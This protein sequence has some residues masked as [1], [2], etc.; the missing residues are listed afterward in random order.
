MESAS[1]KRP[2]EQPGILYKFRS[3]VQRDCTCLLVR[4]QL[5]CCTYRELNDPFDCDP[6]IE[7][8]S[9]D[10]RRAFIEYEL[11]RTPAELLEERR[12][13]LELIFLSPEH[14][15]TWFI[16]AT[17]RFAGILSLSATRDNPLLWAHYARNYSGFAVGYRAKD[18][19][20]LKALPARP[21]VYASERPRL[22]LFA[23]E[24]FENR[25]LLFVKAQH[26]SYEQEWRYLRMEYP[27]GAG[28]ITVPES[29]IVEVCLGPRIRSEDRRVV[30]Q[31]AKQLHDRPRIMQAKL[32]TDRFGLIFESI[33]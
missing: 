20:P 12:K 2:D 30:I 6:V 24:D 11:A 32:M 23:K 1:D 9:P 13:R 10:E 26:W 4:R 3:N 29:S 27:R 15:R 31:A 5:Y 19:G 7:Y 25:E 14:L 18:D 16:M 21:V 33:D 28:L 8:P 22:R 17:D